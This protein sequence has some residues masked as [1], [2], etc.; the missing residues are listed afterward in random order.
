MRA[1]KVGHNSPFGGGNVKEKLEP[2]LPWK[3][4]TN[5][6]TPLQCLVG[7]ILDG[8]YLNKKKNCTTYALRKRRRSNELRLWIT[9][10]RLENQEIAATL[11][12]D[13]RS[14]MQQREHHPLIFFLI[15][16]SPPS[17]LCVPP[18]PPSQFSTHLRHL[19]VSPRLTCSTSFEVLPDVTAVNLE[20]GWRRHEGSGLQKVF[21]CFSWNN[22]TKCDCSTRHS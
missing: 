15:S 21:F 9:L 22:S 4:K 8:F 5:S 19:K 14:L 12:W 1:P 16:F 17:C 13:R 18:T 10:S 3:S 6:V 7:E 20:V 2:S 11:I